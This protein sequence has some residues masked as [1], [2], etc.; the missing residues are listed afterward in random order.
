[1]VIID[2]NHLFDVLKNLQSEPAETE[3]VGRDEVGAVLDFPLHELGGRELHR[4]DA[5]PRESIFN[6]FEV[7]RCGEMILPRER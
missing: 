7:D 6:H 4:R 1:M 5:R 3:D 2:S